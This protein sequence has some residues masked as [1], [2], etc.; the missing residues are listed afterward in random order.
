MLVACLVC[1]HSRLNHDFVT[2]KCLI[3]DCGCYEEEEL[4]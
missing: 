3:C 2:G 4:P 1:G